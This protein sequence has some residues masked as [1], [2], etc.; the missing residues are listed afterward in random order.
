MILSMDLQ[1]HSLRMTLDV[2]MFLRW[3]TM[4]N[5]TAAGAAGV[6]YSTKTTLMMMF[7]SY[8]SSQN[9]Y[10][11][12]QDGRD[13]LAI[14]TML[15]WLGYHRGM[16]PSFHHFNHRGNAADPSPLQFSFRNPSMSHIHG[17]RWIKNELRLSCLG[18]QLVLVKVF[19]SKC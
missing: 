11:L 2:E 3:L 5:C 4:A 13:L 15:L 16:S 10:K 12:K 8:S 19:R 17:K 7:F 18:I 9:V 1:Y 14:A 6:Y